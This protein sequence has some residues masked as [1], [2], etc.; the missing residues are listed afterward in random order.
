MKIY[1][2]LLFLMLY[3]CELHETAEE[4]APESIALKTDK[5]SYRTKDSIKIFLNN[6]SKNVLTLGYRCSYKNLEMF[7]QQKENDKWSENKWFNYMNM[8]CMT[9]PSKVN[10]FSVLK[11]TFSSAE[12]NGTG[13]FRLLLP[14]FI[15][16]KDSSFVVVSNSFVIE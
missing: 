11:H 9:I 4:P 15:P 14:V 13:T 16:G 8:K 12:F 2:L 10:K 3:S 7:Y 1:P 6:N 5:G